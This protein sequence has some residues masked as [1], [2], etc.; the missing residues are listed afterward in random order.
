MYRVIYWFK[1]EQRFTAKTN[2]Q[3]AINTAKHFGGT[4]VKELSKHDEMA[5]V[6][7]RTQTMKD[8]VEQ[9]LVNTERENNG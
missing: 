1:G 5:H 3:D 7:Y 8:K 4:V 6:G 9:R 2:K